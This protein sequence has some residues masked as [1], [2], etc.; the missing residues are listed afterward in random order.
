MADGKTITIP[1]DAGEWTAEHT[2]LATEAWCVFIDRFVEEHP[3]NHQMESEMIAVLLQAQVLFTNSF[4]M[5]KDW[6]EA[7]RNLTV[8]AV[9]CSD[10]F[11]WGCADAERPTY[12]DIPD[13]Y[14]HWR[15]DPSWG[16]AVWCMKRRKEMP[17][18][19]VADMIAADG[20]WMLDEMGLEPNGYDVLL[21]EQAEKRKTG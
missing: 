19:P 3:D 14:A 17:Q 12:A 20:I 11:A 4:W 18:K 10:V 7:A 21:R 16:P 5:E 9:N 6:P 15:K 8:L 13:V 2:I 1:A